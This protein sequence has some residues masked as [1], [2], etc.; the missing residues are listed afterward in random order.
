MKKSLLA[1]AV[2]GAFAGA[3]Q[4]QT[5]VTMFGIVDAALGHISTTNN[6]SV[7][8][9]SSSGINSTRFGVRGT[10]DLGGGMRAAFWL[11]AGL[12]NDNGSFGGT[13]TNNQ[14]TGGTGGGGLTFNRRATVSLL[15]NFGEVRLGRDYVPTFWN[16]TIF[17]PFGTNGVAQSTNINLIT[18]M[19]TSV[20]ASNSIAYFL[21]SNLGGLYGQ[22]TYAFGENNSNAANKRD[23]NHAGLRV[24]YAGGP[25]DIAVAAGKTKY[26]AGDY[27]VANIGGSYNFGFLKLMGQYGTNEVTNVTKWKTGLIGLTAP[28]GQGELRFD[29]AQTKV[30]NLIPVVPAPYSTYAVADGKATQFGIGYVY[31][32]SKRT[33]A[34]A[35]YVHIKNRDGARFEANT[36]GLVSPTLNTAGGKSTGY[37]FGVRHSF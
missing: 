24:G 10:E 7:T 2:L 3:A 33:A 27:K 18:A 30:D 36:N 25:F 34:Y 17:D 19:P 9:L 26:V 12:N 22:A 4:A 21:P 32:L 35:H 37:E 28:L 13:N 20:R 16:L 5:S 23:G 15:G 29:V 1:L 6:G 31:N 14:S 11:E 8:G